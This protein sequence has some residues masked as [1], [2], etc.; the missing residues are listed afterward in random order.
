[1][2]KKLLGIGLIL[3]MTFGLTACSNVIKINEVIAS[4]DSKLV[5]FEIVDN[6]FYGCILVDKNTKTFISD[7]NKKFRI[8]DDIHFYYR[9]NNTK[10]YD[11]FGIITDIEE[12]SFKINNVL[13]D[14]MNVSDTLTIK[15][16]EVKDGIIHNTDNSWY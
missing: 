15:S 14:K 8:G 2:K 5:D 4:P 1:M 3:M 16:S 10:T 13:I 9:K 6:N 11:C 7:E 12:E